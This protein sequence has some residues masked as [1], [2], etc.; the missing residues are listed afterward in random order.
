MTLQIIETGAHFYPV[1]A[2]DH[3]G[4][5]IVEAREGNVTWRITPEGR[6]VN[7]EVYFTHKE[8]WNDF[9]WLHGGSREWLVME[10]QCL[11]IYLGENL[12]LRWEEA[13]ALARFFADP[14]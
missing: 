12:R 11:P 10:L 3:C 14:S 9:E 7:G 5:R 6:L 1:V 4:Q 13:W 8:C 2:C